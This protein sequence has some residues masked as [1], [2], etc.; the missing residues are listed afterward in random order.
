MLLLWAF[1]DWGL[2]REAVLDAPAIQPFD[3]VVEAL[4]RA[5]FPQLVADQTLHAF[6]VKDAAHL[7][8]RQHDAR[9]AGDA[10]ALVVGE[11]AEEITAVS[12]ERL[13]E[14]HRVFDRHAGPLR[15]VL[16]RGMRGIT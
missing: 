12:S 5:P 16:Q 6:R 13:A 4:R 15:E 11:R 1:V 3:G 7:A 14:R 2:V 8:R 10:R 9:G